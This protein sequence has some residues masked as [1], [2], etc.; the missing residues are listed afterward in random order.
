MTF[1]LLSFP[2]HCPSGIFYYKPLTILINYPWAACHGCWTPEDYFCWYLQT[3][4]ECVIYN[5]GNWIMFTKGVCGRVSFDS[6]GWLHLGTW[7]TSQSTF[8]WHLNQYLINTGLTLDWH[9]EWHAVDICNQDLING[10]SMVG[11]VLAD[12]ACLQKLVSTL[13]LLSNG[14]GGGNRGGTGG[15]QGGTG[16]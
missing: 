2:S 12:L 4:F 8:N 13:D 6:F 9:L 11:R 3:S 16:G 5:K 15:E 14:G 1:Y 7:L 10:R